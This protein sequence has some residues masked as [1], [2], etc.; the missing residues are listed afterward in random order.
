MSDLTKLADAIDQALETCPV[1]DVLTVLTG[2]FVGLTI[3]VVRRS[4]NDVSKEIKIDGG[5][6]RD[7]TIHA[8]NQGVTPAQDAAPEPTAF[9]VRDVDTGMLRDFTNYHSADQ[10]MTTYSSR[11][12]KPQFLFCYETPQAKPG[13]A[14]VPAGVQGDAARWRWLNDSGLDSNGNH[15]VMARM[16]GG[17]LLCEVADY[18]VCADAAIAQSTKGA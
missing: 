5:D 16:K 7:I 13:T 17:A 2:C 6:Q 14:P 18:N 11:M 9:V 15:I 10:F 3:E 4:G 8:L 12:L 1:A